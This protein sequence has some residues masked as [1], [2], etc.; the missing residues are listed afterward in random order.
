MGC[1]NGS[2][3]YINDIKI[4]K[5]FINDTKIDELYIDGNCVFTSFNCIDAIVFD[6]A[7]RYTFT[8]PKKCGDIFI[9]MVGGGGSG[10]SVSENDS[11]DSTAMGGYAGREVTQRIAITRDT[12]FNITVGRGGQPV[13]AQ[14][15]NQYLAGNAGMDTIFGNYVAKGGA[16]AFYSSG[17]GYRGEGAIG[18]NGCGGGG[19][20]DGNK[21]V[22]ISN[23]YGGQASSFGNGGD[24]ERGTTDLVGHNGG[25]GAG[26]GGCCVNNG[27]RSQSGAGGR[28]EVRVALNIETLKRLQIDPLYR[29]HNSFDKDRKDMYIE[30]YLRDYYP[31]KT[32]RETYLRSLKNG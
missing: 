11:L 3:F 25:I 24:G 12:T 7:G 6:V 9:C 2:N 22:I 13:I 26:G 19:F 4:D 30:E 21:K 20:K 29:K 17:N 31:N 32:Q 15:G 14:G 16:G 23:S 10:G 1:S 28:G 5:L 18:R 8:V 27:H